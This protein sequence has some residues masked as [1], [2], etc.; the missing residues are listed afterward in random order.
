VRHRGVDV[1]ML[2]IADNALRSLR[3]LGFRSHFA[4]LRRTPGRAAPMPARRPSGSIR[5]IHWKCQLPL[6]CL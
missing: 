3:S 4:F 6:C 5:A 2:G 1:L